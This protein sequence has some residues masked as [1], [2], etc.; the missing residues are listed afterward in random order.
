[1]FP[2]GWLSS[3]ELDRSFALGRVFRKRWRA[4]HVTAPTRYSILHPK[5]FQGVAGCGS[6]LARNALS[7]L[8]A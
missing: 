2:K 7:W 6:L 5:Q 4:E 1:M 3:A 8:A